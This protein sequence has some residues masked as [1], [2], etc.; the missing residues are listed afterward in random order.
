[1]LARGGRVI[2][3]V[4]MMT[5]M[6]MICLSHNTHTKGHR[7]RKLRTFMDVESRTTQV[8]I[9]FALLGFTP[10]FS[11]PA[12]SCT[13]GELDHLFWCDKLSNI[14]PV[15]SLSY[16]SSERSS[17]SSSSSNI[18]SSSSSNSSSTNKGKR[19]FS[20]PKRPDRFCS[21]SN[22]NCELFPQT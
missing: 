12:F 7:G 13:I 21:P 9:F 4:E 15:T 20:S 2:A 18:S 1:M 3:T 14:Y 19:R 6:M 22:R 8:V 10:D 17:S 5:M 11:P 16:C